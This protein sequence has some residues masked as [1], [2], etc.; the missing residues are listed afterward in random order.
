MTIYP[1]IDLLGGKAVRLTAGDYE[2]KTEYADDP[3]AQ[4]RQ[5]ASE[6]AQYLHIVDLDGARAKRPM[7][8]PAIKAIAEA[9][10]I[11][12]QVGGGIRSLETAE[13]VLQYAERI[14]IGTIAVTEPRI[15]K[16]LVERY[17]ANRMVVSVDYKGAELAVN[18]WVE[19]MEV[20]TP[21]LQSKLEKCGVQTVIVTDVARDGMLGGP[22]LD[23]MKQWKAADFEVICAGGVTTTRDIKALANENIDGAI[24]GKALYEHR[25]GLVEALEAA[26]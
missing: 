15:L 21:N 20:S 9:V 23:L 13:Q 26:K 19:S 25:L 18:G 2:A 11:P 17:G 8:L 3:V 14:I 7:N 12:L 5:F 16:K 10:N 4:A 24:I 6:G 22:N 1:A